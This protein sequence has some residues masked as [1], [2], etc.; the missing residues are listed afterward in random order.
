MSTPQP[1][2]GSPTER[3]RLDSLDVARGLMLVVSLAVNAWITMPEWFEHAPWYG[4]HPV[5]LV[6]PVFVTLSGAGLG[7]AYARRVRP[8]RET[9]RVLVLLLAGMAFTALLD[10]LAKGYIEWATF[11]ATGVL[12]LYAAIVAGMALLRIACRVWWHWLVAGLVLA[13]AQ[14]ALLAVWAANCPDGVLSPTCNPSGVID[15]A[16]FGAQHIYVEGTRGH[17][18]SGLVVLVGALASATCGAAGG[19]LLLDRRDGATLTRTL[20]AGIVTVLV[21]ALGAAAAYAFVP[22]FKRLWTAPFALGVAAATVVVLLVLHVVLDGRRVGRL[23]RVARYPLIALGRNSLL[24]YFGSHAVTSTL[25]RTGP[26]GG[27]PVRGRSWAQ[28]W[29]ENLAAGVGADRSAWPLCV[30]AVLA[31]TVLAMVLHARRIYIK[32]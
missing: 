5:D 9:R 31:W 18:P 27:V 15:A 26:S 19:R 24:V 4:V 2:G 10:Y 23:E 20:R 13:A 8:W 3:G 11:D 14:A 25:L 29:Q 16:V 21:T 12:Q 1:L 30:A 7:I 28:V 17:D 32:A 6:F 22:A